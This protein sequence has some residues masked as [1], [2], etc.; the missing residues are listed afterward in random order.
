MPGI[1]INVQMMPLSREQW[2]CA[3]AVVKVIICPV[4][5][6]NFLMEQGAMNLC[7]HGVCLHP[8]DQIMGWVSNY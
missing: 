2:W 6:Q 7:V 3:V 4:M 8:Q 1:K 5:I